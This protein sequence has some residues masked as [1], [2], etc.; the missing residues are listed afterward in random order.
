MRRAAGARPALVVCKPTP[1][2]LPE[3]DQWAGAFCCCATMD[4]PKTTSAIANRAP[5]VLLIYVSFIQPGSL[6]T[7][8][9]EAGENQPLQHP[10]LVAT[11]DRPATSC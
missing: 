5:R 4:A 11:F 6:F 8:N 10:Q 3:P 7:S 2:V 9:E 1:G